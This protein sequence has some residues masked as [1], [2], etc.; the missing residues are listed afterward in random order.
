MSDE[1]SSGKDIEVEIWTDR[2]K[3]KGKMFLPLGGADNSRLSDFLNE[4]P[5]TFFALTDATGQMADGAEVFRSAPFIA[6]NKNVITL[7]RPLNE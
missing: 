7:V 5:K 3:F 1:V 4:S 6:V 2:Y